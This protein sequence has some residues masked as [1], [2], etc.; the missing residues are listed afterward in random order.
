MVSVLV[1]EKELKRDDDNDLTCENYVNF[2][3]FRAVTIVVPAGK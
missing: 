3:V 2:K 1:K